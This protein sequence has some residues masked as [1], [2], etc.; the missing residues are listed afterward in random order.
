MSQEKKVWKKIVSFLLIF[1]VIVALS[2]GTLAL[3]NFPVML[4]QFGMKHQPDMGI[5]QLIM[6]YNLFLS[7]SISLLS[8]IWVRKGNIAGIQAAIIC[9]SLMFAVSF[10]VFLKFDRIDMLLF[11][12]LRAIGMIIFGVLAYKE[13]IKY[14]TKT[15]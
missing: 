14:Q 11:D 10:A 1:Q 12:S 9:G 8:F 2:I 13:Q 5:L 3:V 6:V 4:E 7:L 15:D